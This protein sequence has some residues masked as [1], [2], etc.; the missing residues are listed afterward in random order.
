MAPQGKIR[1]KPRRRRTDTLSERGARSAAPSPAPAGHPTMLKTMPVELPTAPLGVQVDPE[2]GARFGAP[3]SPAADAELHR[4]RSAIRESE[5]AAEL[6]I[7][8]IRIS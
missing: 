7:V 4:L 6:D 2:P 3:E 5:R 8:G 1:F